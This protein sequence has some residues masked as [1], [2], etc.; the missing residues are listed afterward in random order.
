MAVVVV[1]VVGVVA[2]VAAV[3]VVV[4]AV[5]AAAV[6]VRVALS[7][8]VDRVDVRAARREEVGRLRVGR[9]AEPGLLLEVEPEHLAPLRNVREVEVV[10]VVRHHHL[11]L[12]LAQVGAPGAGGGRRRGVRR[13]GEREPGMSPRGMSPLPRCSRR[14]RVWRTTS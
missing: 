4:A 7:H 1:V 8:P 11:R 2:A 6:V 3:V 12:Q 5:A 9:R 14:S 13:G 10:A